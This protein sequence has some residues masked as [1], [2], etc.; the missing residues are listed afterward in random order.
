MSSGAIS[1]TSVMNESRVMKAMLNG[2]SVFFIQ[3]RWSSF[4]S[5]TKSIPESGAMLRRNIRPR[6]R[7]CGRETTSAKRLASLMRS[8]TD[9]SVGRGTEGVGRGADGRQVR[10]RRRQNAEC[11]VQNAEGRKRTFTGPLDH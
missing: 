11:K 6:A 2:M 4:E 10:A 8:S 3:K 9:G 1:S 5:N 7:S